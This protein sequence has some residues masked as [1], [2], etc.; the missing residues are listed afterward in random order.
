LQ[1]LR[2]EDRPVFEGFKKLTLGN[3]QWLQGLDFLRAQYGIGTSAEYDFEIGNLEARRGAHNY[4][5]TGVGPKRKVLVTVDTSKVLELLTS[6]VEGGFAALVSTLRHEYAHVLQ[7]NELLRTL[8]GGRAA[9][10]ET[11][12]AFQAKEDLQEFLA[13]SDE[14]LQTNTYGRGLIRSAPALVGEQLEHAYRSAVGHYGQMEPI[15]K[16][17]QKARYR[18][19]RSTYKLLL[20]A[21]LEPFRKEVAQLESLVGKRGFG[22]QA[23]AF[24]ELARSL[25]AIQ[26]RELRP[27]LERALRAIDADTEARAKP[28]SAAL[29]TGPARPDAAAAA[30]IARPVT[31]PVE[32]ATPIAEPATPI[33]EAPK[34]KRRAE[35]PASRE[36][37]ASSAVVPVLVSE[38]DRKL[39]L[40]Q[41]LLEQHRATSSHAK[42][43]RAIEAS[44]E[45]RLRTNADA[46]LRSIREN[47][48][49]SQSSW[50]LFRSEATKD[51]YK[52]IA[53]VLK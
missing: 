39:S 24:Q 50:S 35:R 13:Y 37:R 1:R 47:L 36:P 26:E 15:D 11:L 43:F 30:P 8:A 17:Q 38:E 53:Q 19:M 52:A 4:A 28:K 12:A 46:V 3:G 16:E 5:A 34:P 25:S 14:I 42:G 51:L 48:S 49:A 10:R 41:D 9:P 21:S 2:D 20:D 29:A 45:R 27:D 44:L 32:A 31:P 22:E 23:L 33:S 7:F 40:I 6:H 18:E